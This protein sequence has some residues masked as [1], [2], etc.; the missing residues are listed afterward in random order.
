MKGGSG[1]PKP[2]GVC[3]QYYR[4]AHKSLDIKEYLVMAKPHPAKP[5][6]G[7]TH[8]QA[9]AFPAFPSRSLGDAASS[10]SGQQTREQK[11]SAERQLEGGD[12]DLD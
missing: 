7:P 11:R 12:D 8:P 4:F 1:V 3:K 10:S 2:R 5:N 6:K 9:R